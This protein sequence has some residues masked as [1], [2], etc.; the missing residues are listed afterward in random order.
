MT[1]SQI[2]E[3][4]KKARLKVGLTQSGVAEKAGINV[5]HYARL[6]RGE[7]TASLKTLKNLLKILKVKSKDVLPF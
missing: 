6:E 7:V 5:N 4:L 1:N 2:G 3:N